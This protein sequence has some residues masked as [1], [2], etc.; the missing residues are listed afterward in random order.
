MGYIVRYFNPE[1][2]KEMYVSYDYPGCIHADDGP[3]VVIPGE[4]YMC[5]H[6]GNIHCP[7]GPAYVQLTS[8]G[9]DQFVEFAYANDNRFLTS[10]AHF[11]KIFGSENLTQ[12]RMAF[13]DKFVKFDPTGIAPVLVKGLVGVRCLELTDQEYVSTMPDFDVNSLAA[14]ETHIERHE[15]LESEEEDEQ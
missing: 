9:N 8:E 13:D 7:T 5:Y 14:Y 6:D 15:R 10:E 3:A 12:V 2:N 11:E 1:N 4:L